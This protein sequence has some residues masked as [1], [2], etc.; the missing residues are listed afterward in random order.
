VVAKVTG[1]TYPAWVAANIL[2]PAGAG[3]I[4]QGQTIWAADREVVYY[5]FPG[6]G[7]GADVFA[8]SYNA[9]YNP[10]GNWYLEGMMSHGAYVASPVDLLRFQGALDGRTGVQL[11]S[12]SSL[13]S[14]VANP[15]VKWSAINATTNTM[16]TYTPSGS[17]YGM[18]WAVNTAGNWWHFGDLPGT[19]GEQVHASNGWGWA[20]FFN[21]RPSNSSG[22]EG[23]VDSDLWA[24]FNSLTASQWL[25][26]NLFDQYGAYTTWMTFSNYQTAF[27]NAVAA[28]K[29][30]SRVEGMQSTG[31]N[32]FRA[33]LVPFHGTAFHSSHNM[34][35]QTYT[36]NAATYASDGYEL[37]T[38]QSFV[39][40]DGTRRYQATWILW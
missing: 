21:S 12:A 31:T 37:V 35:C 6:A 20:A 5:D 4:V 2:G 39:S 11:L 29:Y 30:P 19:V 34:D 32:L 7:S 38:L 22:F 18:G 1:Q 9:A 40:D 13:A 8:S 27:N 16:Y 36:S 25:T 26:T 10:Y 14:M 33:A 3:G 28:G 23:E 15:N 24:A 17:W